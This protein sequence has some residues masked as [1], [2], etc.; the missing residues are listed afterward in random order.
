MA[1]ATSPRQPTGFIDLGALKAAAEGS[2]LQLPDSVYANVIAALASGKHVVIAGPAGS[3]KTSLALAIAK[4]A[5]QAGRSEGAALATASLAR[6]SDARTAS[7]GPCSPPP[8]R[9]S[10]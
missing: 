5:V 8:A 9:R 1:A 3:G 4:A 2:G 6:K 7:P 10:G